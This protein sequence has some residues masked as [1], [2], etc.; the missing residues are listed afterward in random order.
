VNQYQE[1]LSGQSYSTAVIKLP[2][3]FTVPVSY[4]IAYSF[5]TDKPDQLMTNIPQDIDNLRTS[6]QDEYINQIVKLINSSSKNDFERVKK[7]HDL[8]ALV[9]SYD[10]ENYWAKT[11]P[12]QSY[13]NTLKTSLS[14]CAGY[15]NVLKK[16]CDELR[17][18]CV[19]VSG[20]V[21]GVGTSPT[22]ADKPNELNHAW[23]IVAIYGANYLIDCTWDSGSMEGKV[24]EKYYCTNYLFIKPKHLIYSHFPE[25]INHQLLA[26]P[27]SAAQFG[28]LPP[29]KPKFFYFVSNPSIEL[30]KKIHVRDKMTFEYTVKEGYYL[31]YTVIEM[32]NGTEIKLD[33]RH[34]IQVNGSRHT[35]YFSFPSAGQYKINIYYLEYGTNEGKGCGEFIVIAASAS[36]VEFPTTFLSTYTK[37]F[38]IKS[39]IEMPLRKGRTYTFRIKAENKSN[40]I[41]IHGET[42]TLLT[43]KSDGT[44]SRE[45]IIPNNISE[46]SLGVA[47]EGSS[48]YLIIAKYKVN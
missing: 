48:K 4:N 8:T 45:V 38:E 17:I 10:A 25:N 44:F 33:N 3:N 9:L 27:L 14:V 36:K 13:Q 11:I 32:K 41:I 46:L 31:D 24:V 20:Y 1:I 18:P 42:F 2:G 35:A 43:K 30:K 37:N 15:A 21:R 19:V 6:D 40:A 28:V 5:R 34:F 16:F 7:A 47:D 26:S 39:P 29:L 23:N 22:A 12:D